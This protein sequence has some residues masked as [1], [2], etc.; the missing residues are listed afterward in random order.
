MPTISDVARMAKVSKTTVSRVLNQPE[1]VNKSTRMKVLN[2]IK[3]LNYSPSMLARGMRGQKTRT[4]GVVIPDFK[5]LFY[6]EFLEHVESAARQHGYISVVCSTEVNPEREKEYIDE[7]LRRQVDGLILCWYRSVVKNKSFLIELAKKLPVVIMDQPSCDLPVSAVYTDG[8]KGI[9]KL[10]NFF[11]QLG[12]KKIGIIRSLEKYPVGNK[13]FEGYASA[14][15]ENGMA[16][17]YSLVQESEWNPSAAIEATSRLLKRNRPTAIIAVTDLMA[18][19]V[20]KCL[21]DKG[22]SIPGDIAIGGFD[23]ISFSSLISPGLTTIA[24]PIDK[25]AWE[26]TDQLIKRIENRRI[27]NRDIVL[28]NRL[29][30]RESSGKPIG[31]NV[32]SG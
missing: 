10:T 14:L 7:L 4:F 30:V 24:Q 20:L 12:H 32:S 27:R 8:F 11:I 23:D 13:R 3:T 26:A 18:M 22:F 15:K 5:N 31:V 29:I 1:L 25:M 17:D 6:A 2:V 28:E 16:V 9:K 21:V 19:G